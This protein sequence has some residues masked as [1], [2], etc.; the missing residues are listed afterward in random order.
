MD[1][2]NFD[3]HLTQ[4]TN[5]VVKSYFYMIELETIVDY[6]IIYLTSC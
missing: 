4:K 1:R 6:I 5:K 2:E 3:I